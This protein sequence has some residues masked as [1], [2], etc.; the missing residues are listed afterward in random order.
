[1][2]VVPRATWGEKARD[3]IIV[4]TKL[5]MVVRTTCGEISQFGR[6]TQGVR[7]IRLNDDDEVVS[8]TPASQL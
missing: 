5:G 1:M 8:V 3:E 2:A 4:A 6:S 7:V